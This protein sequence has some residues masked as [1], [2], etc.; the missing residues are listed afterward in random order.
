MPLTW[1]QVTGGLDPGTCT[2]RTAPALLTSSGAWKD[3]DAAE[4]PFP[5]ALKRLLGRRKAA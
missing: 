1:E 5:D 2:I 3:Y 4:R